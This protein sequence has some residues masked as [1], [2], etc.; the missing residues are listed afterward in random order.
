MIH[1]KDQEQISRRWTPMNADKVK[2]N[3]TTDGR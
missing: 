2:S 1:P 3:Q